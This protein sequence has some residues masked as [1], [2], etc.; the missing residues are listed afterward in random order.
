MVKILIKIGPEICVPLLG[1]KTTFYA[2]FLRD[3]V[4]NNNKQ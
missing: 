4:S 1:Y 2:V 3:Q